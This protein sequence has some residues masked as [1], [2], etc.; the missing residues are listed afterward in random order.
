MICRQSGHHCRKYG[1]VTA[2]KIRLMKVQ[3]WPVATYGC[4]RWT[5]EKNEE[6]RLDTF[7][8]KE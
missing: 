6:R 5:L 1:K 2:T 8:L 4:E 3:V 7:K